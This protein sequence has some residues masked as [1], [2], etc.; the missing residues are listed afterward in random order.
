LSVTGKKDVAHCADV[1]YEGVRQESPSIKVAS[2]A[3]RKAVSSGGAPSSERSG[4]R[5]RVT[6]AEN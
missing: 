1:W 2:F 6:K 5:R 4:W 3:L